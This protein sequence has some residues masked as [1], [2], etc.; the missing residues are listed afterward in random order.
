MA[1]SAPALFDKGQDSERASNHEMAYVFYTRVVTL[2]NR[3]SQSPHSKAL[4]VIF[5]QSIR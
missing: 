3:V 4:K 1:R 2:Y 5:N